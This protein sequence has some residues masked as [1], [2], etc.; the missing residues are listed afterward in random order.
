MA[1]LDPTRM[2]RQIAC[3]P[4]EADF[5]SVEEAD[6]RNGVAREERGATDKATE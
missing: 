3:Q 5:Q 1:C 6:A 2:R 4:P